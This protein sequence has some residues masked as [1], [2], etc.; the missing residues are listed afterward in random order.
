VLDDPVLDP[1]H[2]QD[3]REQVVVHAELVGDAA[4]TP[5]AEAAKKSAP[6]S[7]TRRDADRCTDDHRST[8]SWTS[9]TKS[10]IAQS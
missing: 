3:A 5:V 4:P 8:A 9:S 7:E 1:L 10:S 6:R 2:R